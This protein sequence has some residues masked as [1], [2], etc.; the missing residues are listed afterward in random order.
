MNAMV[1]ATL[2]LS[3]CASCRSAMDDRPSNDSV[4]VPGGQ[5]HL[6][7]SRGGEDDSTLKFSEV[8]D[9]AVN[10][11]HDVFILENRAAT[12][13]QLTSSGEFKRRF[14]RRGRGPGEFV[15]PYTIGVAG[16]SVW[17]SDVLLKRISIF[18]SATGKPRTFQVPVVDS[19]NL[20]MGIV[21]PVG[22]LS[23]GTVL[24]A[25][26]ATSQR[27]AD[28][29][30]VY[31]L[32]DQSSSRIGSFSSISLW[33]VP[34]ASG[35]LVRRFQ[36]F[37][38]RAIFSVS[39]DGHF[40]VFVGPAIEGQMVSNSKIPVTWIDLQS[41]DSWHYSVDYSPV[42]LSKHAIDSTVDAVTKG[43]TR[44][45]IEA[46]KRLHSPRFRPPVWSA[47]VGSSGELLLGRSDIAGNCWQLVW[48]AGRHTAC[49]SFP[50]GFLPM[51]IEMDKVWGV[52]R[53][54]FGAESIALLRVSPS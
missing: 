37:Q 8:T 20:K 29:P 36:P 50:I 41:R 18:P 42:S 32:K 33:E 5:V 12:I 24:V 43:D 49:L 6:V 53:D 26:S 54:Q 27:G 1:L 10:A 31:A 25:N 39:H 13:T 21:W 7:W 2:V 14:G 19:S 3:A 34:G 47:V 9:I 44:A 38:S 35:F 30:G 4:A 52:A 48:P 28:S 16:D 46:R 51:A 23:D 45:K 11:A 17:V 15:R 40:I 22:L